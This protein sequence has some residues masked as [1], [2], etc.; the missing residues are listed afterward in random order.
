MPAELGQGELTTEL[1]N[2]ETDAP[3]EAAE[4]T[5]EP[6]NTDNAVPAANSEA[7]KAANDTTRGAESDNT[8][9]TPPAGDY[10]E[11]IAQAKSQ[12]DANAMD[13]AEPLYQQALKL[14]PQ[15][16]EALTGL[17]FVALNKGAH[18]E[19]QRLA[20]QA[21]TQDPTS[22]RAWIALASA[23]QALNKPNEATKAYQQC[24]AQGKG[25]YLAKC[26]QMVP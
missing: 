24:V 1:P 8:A 9:D 6:Q 16:G 17:A 2:A 18:Q 3:Q 21:T 22:S 11:L 7:A 4:A 15:G 23:F 13:N 14:N 12:E 19:A 26:Q 20:E 5:P 10:A 25:E